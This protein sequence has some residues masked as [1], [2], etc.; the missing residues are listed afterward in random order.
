MTKILLSAVTTF[1][2]I[3]EALSGQCLFWILGQDDMPE[4]LID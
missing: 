3:A 2:A 4:E 1:V